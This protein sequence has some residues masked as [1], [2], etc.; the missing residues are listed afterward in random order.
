MLAGIKDYFMTQKHQFVYCTILALASLS[1][2]ADAQNLNDLI[3]GSTT[4]TEAPLNREA[5]KLDLVIGQT[6][7]YYGGATTTLT[8]SML[9]FDSNDQAVSVIK[10]IT[11]SVG[12]PPNF[13]VRAAAV[14]NAAAVILEKTRMILYNESFM[15]QVAQ[16]ARTDWA[17]LSI[18]AHEVG[19]HLSG[20]T[21]TE[22][23]SRPPIELEAD[24]FS[25]F[26]V[27]RL[28]GSLD[29]ALAAMRVLP[30][31]AGSTTHPGKRERLQAITAGWQDAQSG[32]SPAVPAT[33]NKQ[34]TVTHTQ[35]TLPVQASHT[36]LTTGH[37]LS[38]SNACAAAESQQENKLLAQCSSFFSD[39]KYS[40]VKL[41]TVTGRDTQVTG[42][43]SGY[44]CE[45]TVQFS[46]NAVRTDVVDVVQCR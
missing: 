35:Q 2:D 23:G 16:A 20:H 24:R 45:L 25:G 9:S 36:L 1:L 22:G 29:D 41:G 38:R 26:V 31:G 42:D 13:L 18:M 12:L 8:T 43:F 3:R 39:S 21:I 6:C 14:P 5:A 37:A 15:T 32:R 19:H 17:G 27:A 44:D 7:D 46:C 28:G 40:Q 11:D 10:R 4:R 30:D 33:Q 34:C